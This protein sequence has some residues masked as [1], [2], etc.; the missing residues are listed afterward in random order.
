[1]IQRLNGMKCVVLTCG[2]MWWFAQCRRASALTVFLVLAVAVAF[3]VG[4][5][6]KPAAEGEGGSP[7]DPAALKQNRS[8]QPPTAGPVQPTTIA[9]QNNP[10]EV[11]KQLNR[12]LIRWAMRNK[13]T[14]ASFEEFVTSA[15]VQVPPAPAGQK[16][17]L[18]KNRIV[19]VNQ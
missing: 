8:P 2:E 9:P 19:L 4:C 13:R 15:Q 3:G 11:L 17:T 12:E 6:D 14:P 5:S 10:E 7:V 16:Y 18:N 1:M